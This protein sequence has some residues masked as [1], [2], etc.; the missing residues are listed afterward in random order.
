MCRLFLFSSWSHLPIK[1][2]RIEK[3]AGSH[4]G[5]GSYCVITSTIKLLLYKAIK[6]PG[7]SVFAAQS[8]RISGWWRG[9][10]FCS[11]LAPPRGSLQHLQHLKCF[12]CRKCLTRWR[13]RLLLLVD[14]IVPYCVSSHTHMLYFDWVKGNLHWQFS[15]WQ[16]SLESQWF[17]IDSENIT[18][19]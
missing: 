19:I 17:Q 5:R 6:L 13:P 2:C 1:D 10:G 4:W 12:R 14:I 7:L 3:A 8:C 16:G 18:Y 11:T 9:L 15:Q